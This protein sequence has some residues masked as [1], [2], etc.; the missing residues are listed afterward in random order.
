MLYTYT[1]KQEDNIFDKKRV[2][3]IFSIK[4]LKEMK[5]KS[6][7]SKSKLDGNIIYGSKDGSCSLKRG[8]QTLNKT[9]LWGGGAPSETCK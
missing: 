3:S 5:K 6:K 9:V 4:I 7:F 2:L 1:G 8:A